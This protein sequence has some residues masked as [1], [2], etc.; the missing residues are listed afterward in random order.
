MRDHFAYH[1][2]LVQALPVQAGAPAQEPEDQFRAV[3]DRV[4]GQGLSF[5]MD[6]VI[7]HTAIDAPLV[8]EHPEWYRWNEQGG[9]VHPGAYEGSEWVSWEDLAA[10]D[11]D[12]SSDQ[13]NLWRYWLRRLRSAFFWER[14][15]KRLPAR[16]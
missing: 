3:L 14:K 8:Q 6:L 11:N 12:K 16:G 10:I 13:D 2:F 15:E 1:P 4:H 7:N 5:M 9:L